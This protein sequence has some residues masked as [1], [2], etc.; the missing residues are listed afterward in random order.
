MRRPRLTVENAAMTE[1]PT[2]LRAS[3]GHGERFGPIP[4]RGEGVVNRGRLCALTV[5]ACLIL[6]AQ[7]DEAL[8]DLQ[9]R[10][11]VLPRIDRHGVTDDAGSA[12]GITERDGDG[13]LAWLRV[14][15]DSN[16]R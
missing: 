12:V 1:V 7:R 6:G 14:E 5:R 16:R 15:V 8:L 4:L 9:L 3:H 2:V 13:V 11:G 10:R